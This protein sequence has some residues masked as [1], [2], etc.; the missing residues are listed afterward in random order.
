MNLTDI[1]HHAPKRQARKRIGRGDGSG[2]GKTAGR[3]HKGQKSRSGFSRKTGHEGGQM[4]LFR[5]MPKVGF[6]NERFR[7]RLSVI[8][9]S[10]LNAFNPDAEVTP[11]SFQQAGIVKNFH[12]GIKILGDGEID[13]P[14]KVK[15]HRVSATAK[16]KI[17]KAGGTVEELAPRPEPLSEEDLAKVKA[18]QKARRKRRR[19]KKKR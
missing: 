8:N 4:P 7:T 1:A 16:A 14:L 6:S 13:R 5:R 2:H 3:G 9:V 15:V 10:A 12:D 18:R 19:G 11:E 17:E